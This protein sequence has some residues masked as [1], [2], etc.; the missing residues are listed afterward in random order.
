MRVEK[1][2]K[3]LI[4]GCVS[5]TVFSLYGFVMRFA[6]IHTLGVEA[7]SLN[8]LFTEVLAMLSLAEMGVGYAIVYHL[9]VPLR[10]KDERKLAQLMN[11]YKTAYRFI[12]L[13]IFAAGLCLLP[14]VHLFVSRME[15]DLGYLRLIYFLFLVQTA[16]SYLWSYKSSLFSAD[17]KGYMTVRCSLLIR[18]AF[19][20][21]NIVFLLLTRNYIVYLLIQI[22]STLAVNLAISR[23][24]D[25]QYP[26]LK[27]AEQLPKEE[28]EQI[29]SNIKYIFV[30]TLSGKITNSTDN[31][32][33]SVMVGTL[34]IGAYSC[35]SMIVN[36]FKKF[37]MQINQATT[38]S[39][40]N[41]VAEGNRAYTETVLRRLTFI[42]YCPA[43]FAA[44]GIYTVSTPFIR[45]LY[46][47]EYLLPMPVVF[48]CVLNLVVYLTKNPLWSVMAASGLFKQ[49]RNISVIGDVLNLLISVLLGRKLGIAGILLGTNCTLAIQWGLKTLLLFR[50]SLFFPKGAYIR[51]VIK[52]LGCGVFCLLA[53]QGLCMRLPVTNLYLQIFVYGICTEM[54]VIGI[55]FLLFHS[56][57]EF[58][59]AVETGKKLLAQKAGSEPGG[60]KNV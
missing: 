56:T 43:I 40:G 20:A 22:L 14:F 32:L 60:E 10:E 9:Y 29:F 57:P 3:N 13:V 53:A 48:V 41:L 46:G 6:L 58:K 49:N 47:E 35:Y 5:Q 19:H 39:I 52:A 17:Q 38:A 50:Q 27:K 30:G 15:I 55:H 26:F 23:K 36:T 4:Y 24:A 45:L 16:S 59:Y 54:I 34:H 31:I 11:L 42:T 12:A 8:G 7:V 33:I 37:V 2:L 21:V 51:L 28:K 25:R 1:S 18:G 44:A